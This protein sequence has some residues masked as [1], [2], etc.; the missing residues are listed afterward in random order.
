LLLAGH[1]TISRF[2]EFPEKSPKIPRKFPEFFHVFLLSASYV[3]RVMRKRPSRHT[4]V[5]QT[6]GE[7]K[8]EARPSSTLPV[9]RAFVLQLSADAAPTPADLAGRVEHVRSGQAAHFRSLGELLAFL[10]RVLQLPAPS[11]ARKSKRSV[12]P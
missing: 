4:V 12:K 9:E 3:L 11:A 10:A 7:G 2:P 1:I 5:A 8:T 6:Q